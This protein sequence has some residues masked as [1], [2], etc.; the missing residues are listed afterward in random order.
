MPRKEDLYLSW[1]KSPDGL[2][3]ADRTREYVLRYKSPCVMPEHILLALFD[4]P[5]I[6]AMFIG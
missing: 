5:E 1:L 4:V 3:F 2:A 6:Q